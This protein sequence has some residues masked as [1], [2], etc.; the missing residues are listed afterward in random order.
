MAL[1]SSVWPR[2]CFSSYQDDQFQHWA[3]K[4]QR[5]HLS[6]P[7]PPPQ[8]FLFCF[9]CLFVCF[10]QFWFCLKSNNTLISIGTVGRIGIHHFTASIVHLFN[11][12]KSK[13]YGNNENTEITTYSYATERKLPE[14]ARP[15]RG[16]TSHRLLAYEQAY[17]FKA[18][19]RVIKSEFIY[20][21]PT[22]KWSREQFGTG[23]GEVSWSQIFA[24]ASTG[25]HWHWQFSMPIYNHN[26]TTGVGVCPQSLSFFRPPERERTGN[27]R[28]C[29]APVL[30]N[31]D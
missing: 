5:I 9:V 21:K 11:T 8:L 20:E 7:S 3:R 24:L 29:F 4:K 28:C 27:A 30:W 25:I 15:H 19:V 23:H 31:Q 2:D 12:V 1:R 16:L 22:S 6:L 10:L 13:P 14:S 18:S 26:S 17:L